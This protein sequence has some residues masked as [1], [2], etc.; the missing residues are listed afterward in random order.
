[1]R[2]I[3]RSEQLMRVT[4]EG[5]GVVGQGRE[6]AG[7]GGERMGIPHIL[8]LPL[9]SQETGIAKRAGP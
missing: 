2:D 7:G 1:M 6:G 3:V 9:P 8:E 5:L 4:L